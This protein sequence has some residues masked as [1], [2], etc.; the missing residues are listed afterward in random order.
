M[1]RVAGCVLVFSLACSGS[2]ERDAGDDATLTDGSRDS[3]VDMVESGVDSHDVFDSSSDASFDCAL[4]SVSHWETGAAF[5][6]FSGRGVAEAV[7]LGSGKVALVGTDDGGSGRVHVYDPVADT[8]E[9]LGF[10]LLINNTATR[11]PSGRALGVG[12]GALCG[13]DLPCDRSITQDAAFLISDESVTVTASPRSARMAHSAVLL[14]DGRAVVA[15][16]WHAEY[17]GEPGGDTVGRVLV[18]AEAYDDEDAT[19]GELAPMNEARWAFSLTRLLDGRVL[20]SGGFDASHVPLATAEVYDPEAD[21]WTTVGS[22][23]TAR[24]W[25]EA[26]LLPSGRV[27]VMGGHIGSQAHTASA[28]LFNPASATW[29]TAQN[30]PVAFGYGA[31]VAMASGRVLVSGGFFGSSLDGSFRVL[32]AVSLFDESEGCWQVL[33]PLNVERFKFGLVELLDGRIFASPGRTADGI[34]DLPE[35]GVIE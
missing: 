20:A 14:E 30:V 7:L 13:P 10:T 33:S 1:S 34:T 8:W 32:D 21:E 17:V 26:Q 29:T 31:S 18:E 19:W 2:H 3:G 23:E 35:L 11:L 28:E 6:R 16:G 25:H 9:D 24:A 27:L 5:G 12:N 22:M 4:V 15:G